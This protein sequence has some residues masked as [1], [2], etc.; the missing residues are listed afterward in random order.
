MPYSSF[1]HRSE[2]NSDLRDASRL[3]VRDYGRP[4]FHPEIN[5]RS[6]NLRRSGSVEMILYNDA[7]ERIDRLNESR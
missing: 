7:L 4:S 6:K 1:I 5:K 2:N 3:S